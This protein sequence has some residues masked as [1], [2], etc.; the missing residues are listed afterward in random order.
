MTALCITGSILD[1]LAALVSRLAGVLEETGVLNGHSLALGGDRTGALRVDS[2]SNTH[3]CESG[4]E[5]S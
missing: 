3:V 4:R 5:A 1:L 2:L